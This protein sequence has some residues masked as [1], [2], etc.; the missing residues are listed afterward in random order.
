MIYNFDTINNIT[1]FLQNFSS[2]FEI[3]TTTTYDIP[4]KR[5]YLSM[6]QMKKLRHREV[7]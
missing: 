5:Y 6:F 2:D 1:N 7:E 4:G 3:I